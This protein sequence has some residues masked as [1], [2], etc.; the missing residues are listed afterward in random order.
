MNTYFKTKRENK[1]NIV[2]KND[3]MD[4]EDSV[5]VNDDQADEIMTLKEDLETNIDDDEQKINIIPKK[6][7]KQESKQSKLNEIVASP[8][9]V[10]LKRKKKKSK[11]LTNEVHIIDDVEKANNEITE[12]ASI[13]TNKEEPK[14]KKPKK[15]NK[16]IVEDVKLSKKKVKLFCEDVL[17]N[18]EQ[19]LNK[20]SKSLAN[21]DSADSSNRECNGCVKEMPLEQEPK[22]LVLTDKYQNLIDLI[23]ENSSAGKKYAKLPSSEFEKKI[24]EFSK[25]TKPKLLATTSALQPKSTT[26]EEPPYELKTLNP[27]DTDFIKNFE[28]QKSKLLESIS[29]RQETAKYVDDKSMFI[30]KHG[31]VLFFGS[32]INDIKGYGEV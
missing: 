30:A 22:E 19:T 10:D 7:K 5:V 24:E 2:D 17:N 13:K 27:D 12:E 4:D 26:I 8:L 25:T 16:E 21:E 23:I 1:K 32:N 3:L 14:K 9:N 6:K 11:T 15:V 20:K 29:N 31:N 18:S 28:T